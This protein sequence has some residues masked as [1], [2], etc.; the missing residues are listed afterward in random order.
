MVTGR[1]GCCSAGRRGRT[2]RWAR[3]RGGA[4]DR[5]LG[6]PA[7]APATGRET[8]EAVLVSRRSSG[9]AAVVPPER[10]RPARRPRVRPRP[11]ET[12]EPQRVVPA[13]G[14]G[15]PGAGAPPVGG[16]V[17]HRPA[18]RAPVGL[19]AERADAGGRPGLAGP[20][21]LLLAVVRVVCDAESGRQCAP[22]GSPGAP[23]AYEVRR[24]RPARE[25]V[26]QAKR[27]APRISPALREP[28][29]CCRMCG[30]R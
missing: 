16:G 5:P 29:Y 8:V 7:P 4:A 2:V 21:A 9:A 3:P 24:L 12:G 20:V 17:D 1:G 18:A 27:E 19:V 30:L 28:S 23:V 13:E 10:P 22:V 26:G 14:G 25:A 11:A 6:A 15:V